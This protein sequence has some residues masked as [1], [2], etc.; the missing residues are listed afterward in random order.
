MLRDAAVVD[1]HC[2]EG[3]TSYLENASLLASVH[4]EI[5]RLEQDSLADFG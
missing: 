2:D 3:R 4:L 1:T 5:S